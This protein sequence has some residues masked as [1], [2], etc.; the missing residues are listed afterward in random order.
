MTRL[1]LDLGEV[2]S[3][4]SLVISQKNKSQDG[5]LVKV[6]MILEYREC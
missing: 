3:I 6:I 1:V 5:R 4:F 2:F